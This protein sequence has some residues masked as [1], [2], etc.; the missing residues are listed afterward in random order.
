M[1]QNRKSIPKNFAFNKE[2]ESQRSSTIS[3]RR[4]EKNPE[5]DIIEE[6]IPT[7]QN[8]TKTRQYIKGRFLGKGGFAKCYELINKDNNKIFAAKML[9]KNSLKT[10]RQKQKLI[11]EIKIHK[12][13]HHSNIVAFEHNF[14]D[15]DNFYILLEFTCVWA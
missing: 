15:E 5:S 12:S 14:E 11:T 2:K 10:E 7:P 13:C 3:P 9:Q 6:T 8:K 4:K 1:Y